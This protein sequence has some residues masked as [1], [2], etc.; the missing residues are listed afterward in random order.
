MS[1]KYRSIPSSSAID[2]QRLTCPHC[3]A[4]VLIQRGRFVNHGPAGGLFRCPLS[5]T[6]P[7]PKAVVK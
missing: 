5:G 1:I 6:V 2:G 7:P 4:K 3:L